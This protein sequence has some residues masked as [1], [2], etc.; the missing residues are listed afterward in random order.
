VRVDGTLAADG[1]FPVAL[2]WNN[3]LVVPNP[4]PPLIS[5]DVNHNG[6]IGD[7]AFSGFNDWATI[8]LQQMSARA[9]GFGFSEGGGLKPGAGG[10]LKPG[11]GGG[12]DNE[13]GGLKPGAGGGLKPGAGGG[14]KPGAGG[15]IEQ[16]TQT[17][18]STVD[19]PTGL[20]CTTQLTMTDG[21]LVPG[22]TFSSG[23]FNEKAKGIPLTW[24]GPDFGQIR[25]YTVWRAT[26]SFTT[27][28]SVVTNILKFQQVGLLNTGTPPTPQFIDTFQ[29]K[30]STTY[31]YFVTDSN[32]PGAKSKASG[33]LVVTF[34]K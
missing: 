9:S 33:P 12:V 15:G 22:C 25:S 28:K 21:T 7:P 19:P 13:G 3:D 14:L 29:L 10:G 6:V 5:E 24:S 23:T 30:S 11:A 8:D 20:S 18:N 2:D 1:T 34:S 4:V 31:T 27:M 17:A 32:L 26:G 16:D